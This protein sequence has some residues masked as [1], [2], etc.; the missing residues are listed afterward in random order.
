[1]LVEDSTSEALSLTPEKL[2]FL[3][4]EIDY[5]AVELR[6]VDPICT[7]FLTMCK[8]VL[9]EKFAELNG[10]RIGPVGA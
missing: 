7:Y 5:L 8:Q 2:E 6:P 9:I 3:I 1:M 4:T 10:C